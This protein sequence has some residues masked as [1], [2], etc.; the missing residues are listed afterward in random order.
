MVL[1]SSPSLSCPLA[2]SSLLLRYL[3]FSHPAVP[4]VKHT[5]QNEEK[6]HPNSLH[7][8]APAR[9]SADG[10]LSSARDDRNNGNLESLSSLGHFLK[11]SSATL[12]FNKIRDSCQ[13]I[14][15]YGHKLDVDGS[16]VSD[17]QLCLKYIGEAL[18]AAKVETEELKGLMRKF[19]GQLGE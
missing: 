9:C 16:A 14:Q 18:E 8:A 17:E 1:L 7:H 2:R 11:G 15:Q 6:A 4:A 5:Q 19:F 13:L 12:G 10:K 3:D